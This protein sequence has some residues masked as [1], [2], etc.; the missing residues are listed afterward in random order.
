MPAPPRW[1]HRV[2]AGGEAGDSLLPVL[3]LLAQAFFLGGQRSRRPRLPPLR[4]PQGLHLGLQLVR[5]MVVS[6]S[7]IRW[8]FGL[9]V[10]IT[11]SGGHSGRVISN[12]NF[13]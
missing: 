3:H 11:V 9:S 6:N 13:G 4:L 7:R 5:P 1:T 8:S 12:G 10:W 2:E